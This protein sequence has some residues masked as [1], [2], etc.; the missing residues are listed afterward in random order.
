MID[1]SHGVAV[2]EGV[3]RALLRGGA[4]LRS[5]PEGDARS[6]ARQCVLLGLCAIDLGWFD[7]PPGM[8][9]QMRSR[10]GPPAPASSCWPGPASGATARG[11][12]SPAS[13]RRSSEN[14]STAAPRVG[15]EG[16]GLRRRKSSLLPALTEQLRAERWRERLGRRATGIVA[17]LVAEVLLVLLMLT[18]APDMGTPKGERRT[19][20]S[21]SPAEEEKAEPEQAPAERRRPQTA[22]ETHARCG[23]SET[24]ARDPGRAGPPRRRCHRRSFRWTSPAPT[25]RPRR[26][27]S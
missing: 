27:R 5:L 15:V 18:L 10:D 4:T 25:S 19:T 22:A 2:A 9:S 24:G 26:H 3:G 7:G 13:G 11:V 8:R 12:S 6:V 23:R 16:R 1:R 14:A 21:F 20:F 17:A